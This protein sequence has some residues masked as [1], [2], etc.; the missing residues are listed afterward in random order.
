MLVI[1][2]IFGWVLLDHLL[3]VQQF[4]NVE[5]IDFGNLAHFSLLSTFILYIILLHLRV[6]SSTF[7]GRLGQV[8]APAAHVD[9]WC[10][11]LRLCKAILR[12]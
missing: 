2:H 6:F 9:S 12:V 3:K 5:P 8:S 7:L 11:Y 10:P 1:H 4:G